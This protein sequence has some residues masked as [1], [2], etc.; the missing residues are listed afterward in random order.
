MKLVWS[1][2]CMSNRSFSITEPNTTSASANLWSTKSSARRR[3]S[4]SPST[5]LRNATFSTKS[6]LISPMLSQLHKKQ[7]TP[8]VAKSRVLKTSDTC[9]SPELEPWT[10]AC[11]FADAPPP[12]SPFASPYP[13]RPSPD[14]TPSSASPPAPVA[15]FAASANLAAASAY[16]RCSSAASPAA[17]ASSASANGSAQ[18]LALA[19][20]GVP[21]P[22]VALSPATPPPP[23]PTAAAALA[24]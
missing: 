24:Q 16:F 11:V 9:S 21:P 12:S 6:F 22:P 18:W 8:N 4:R 3:V 10:T 23:L 1:C 15:K 14:P 17:L 13:G 2:M 7:S 5:A 20:D 19:T